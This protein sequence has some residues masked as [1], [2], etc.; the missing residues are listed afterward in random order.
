MKLEVLLDADAFLAVRKLSLLEAMIAAGTWNVRMRMAQ[1]AARHE[2]GSID[3]E[4]RALEAQGR[5]SVHGVERRS[6]ADHLYRQLVRDGVDKGEAEAVGWAVHF[7]SD[8]LVFVSV[9]HRAR[10]VAGRHRIL[11]ADVMDLCV[12][13]VDRAEVPADLLREKLSPWLDREQQLG[14]P[15]DLVPF[16]FDEAYQ[17]RCRR[18]NAA[19]LESTT[20]RRTGA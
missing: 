7:G 10:D 15:R 2:L 14:R 4:L 9:D 8:E 11:A 17:K 12:L 6:D 20:P 19:P 13:L 3:G 1:Y 18:W 5:L 16:D